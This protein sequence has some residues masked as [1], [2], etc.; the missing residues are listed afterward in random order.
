MGME[1]GSGLNFGAG[2]SG[3]GGASGGGM[4]GL[5]I[6]T[7]TQS[8]AS[9]SVAL[10]KKYTN[11]IVKP[12][13]NGQVSIDT[14]GMNLEEGKQYSFYLYIDLTSGS[15]DITFDDT[16]IEWGNTSPT[17]TAM[18]MYELSFE[19]IDGGKTWVGNQM[20]SWLPKE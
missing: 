4:N 2:G 7:V 14:T 5:D 18:V 19:T 6:K 17:M 10:E 11:Y 8:G 9:I 13:A 1:K 20:F 12:T 15:Y 16:K 3:G